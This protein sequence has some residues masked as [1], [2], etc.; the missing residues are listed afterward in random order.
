MQ[1]IVL[2]AKVRRKKRTQFE[3]AEML[4]SRGWDLRLLNYIS[5]A[6]SLKIV[7]LGEAR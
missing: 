5:R 4:G 2:Q 1:Q 3:V 7:R 6:Q